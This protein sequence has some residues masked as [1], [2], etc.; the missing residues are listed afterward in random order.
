MNLIFLIGMPGVGKS[1][2]GRAWAAQH[3]WSFIDLDE[4]ITELTGV[5]TPE[6]FASAGEEGF[7]AIESHV[8]AETVRGAGRVNTIIATGGGTPCAPE[9]IA[10]MKATG[11]VVLLK[12]RP[13][14]LLQRLKDSAQA[15]PLLRELSIK[16]LE[17]LESQRADVYNEA[18]LHL[19][20]G[21]VHE[22][23]FAQILEACTNLRS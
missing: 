6:I 12:A 4:Q 19:E 10:L 20:A 8:L 21:K 17:A 9:N 2:W 22:G 18:H 15:R 5:G 23:T 11:L 13:P 14:M 16:S 3:H 1:F 7:R